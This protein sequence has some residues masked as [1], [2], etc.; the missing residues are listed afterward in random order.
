MRK[1]LIIITL[2]IAGTIGV[3]GLGREAA[4]AAVKTGAGSNGEDTLTALEDTVWVYD[5]LVPDTVACDVI[6]ADEDP[7]TQLSDADYA[8]VAA[9]LGV[10]IPAIKAVVEIEAG[11]AHQGF[12]KPGKPIVNFDPSMYRK[13]GGKRSITSSK[14]GQAKDQEQLE[15][16]M[17]INPV[18][19]IKGTFW[20]MFQIGGF[21]WK[22]CDT[23]SP[24]EFVRLMSR[25]ER[26]QLEL[27]ARLITNTGMLPYLQ[28]K[29]WAG[30]A[31][32]YNGASY[33]ARGYHT[34]M[35]RAYA[36]Y[37]K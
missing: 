9:E 7:Y 8:A 31:R 13:F 11:K 14:R 12:W 18:T 30:F 16:A 4:S 25:S 2:A 32:R 33:A 21:N 1:I 23:K 5:T 34:K 37:K 17:R 28:R 19:A 35:A 22:L 26:D 15:K 20:G 24:Q 3:L 10:E 6:L 27:F 36:K 29:D